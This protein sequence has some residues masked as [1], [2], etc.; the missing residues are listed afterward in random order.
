M[1]TDTIDVGIDLGT[2]NSV[3]AVA[4]DGKVD[5]VRNGVDDQITPSVV[6]YLKNGAV[7]VGRKSY[8]HHRLVG[9]GSTFARFKRGMGRQTDLGV[10]GSGHSVT[11][12]TLSAEVLKSLRSDAE[13]FLGHPVDAAVVTVP[14]MFELVQCEATQRA[15]ALAGIS[16]TVLLQE[17]I[18]AGL[19]YGYDRELA[20]SY[21]LVYDYGSGTFDVTLLR[22]ADGHLSVVDLDGDNFLGGSDWDRRISGLL[23]QRLTERGFDLWS[24]DDPAGAQFKARLD[25]FAEQEKIR[26]T[27]AASTEAY[28]DG[29]LTDRRGTPIETSIP[30]SRA[31][32]EHLIE[33]DIER[34]IHIATRLLEKQSIPKAS[35]AKVILVGGPTRTPLLRNMVTARMGIPIESSIDPMTVVAEGAATFA[36]SQRR[37]TSASTHRSAGAA[38]EQEI[39]LEYRPTV[40]DEITHVGGRINGKGAEGWSVEV[41]RGDGGWASGRVPVQN[42]TFFTPLTLVRRQAN[43]FR[44]TCFDAAGRPIACRPDQFTIT[45]GLVV[46]A[47]P[48]A[49]PLLV[50]VQAADGEPESKIMVPKGT[51]LPVSRRERFTA[52]RSVAPGSTDDVLD[53]NVYEG[54]FKRPRLNRHV[55][56]LR[57]AGTRISRPL[58]EGADIELTVRVS[59]SRAVTVRAFIPLLDLTLEEV[60]E[61]KSLPRE[62]PGELWQAIVAD[63]QRVRGVLDL[64]PADAARILALFPDFESELADAG[65][66]PDLLARSARRAREISNEIDLVEERHRWPLKVKQVNSTLEWASW[67]VEQYGSEVHLQRLRALRS[68]AQQ[69]IGTGQ[70]GA[71]NRANGELT[72]LAWDVAWE[73]E[74]FW[75]DQLQDLLQRA[76][77]GQMQHPPRLVSQGQQSLQTR[78]FDLMRDTCLEIWRTRNG[79]VAS[80]YTIGIR[81]G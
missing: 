4:H 10:S 49:R 47:P 31:E 6:R 76:D 11:P 19:A 21:L 66:D 32:Y 1:S 13:R 5:V 69:A 14:A 26:L 74:D 43:T 56:T 64:A 78:D 61:N 18:A 28:F 81:L 77:S 27:Q 40:D 16:Q 35:V 38:G 41:V 55:G 59:V 62:E 36:A 29:E 80:P 33:A 53:I 30:L 2:S 20:N 17:P 60:L 75:A 79:A 58:P 7:Q 48:L 39:T 52:T 8:E 45:H 46:D 54:E 34:S 25:L 50:E 63:E 68:E 70:I 3:V 67:V 73:S 22:V 37:E 12:E 15:A 72:R 44:L 51:P 65:D 9:D 23:S 42:G 57:I 71:A 24:P